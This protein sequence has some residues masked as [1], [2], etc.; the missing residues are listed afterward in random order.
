[1]SLDWVAML[2]LVVTTPANVTKVIWII[3]NTVC[4]SVKV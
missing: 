1:M 2:I 3:R 4:S